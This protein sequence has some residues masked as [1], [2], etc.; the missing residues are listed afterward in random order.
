MLG[1]FLGISLAKSAVTHIADQF[2]DNVK[3]PK[4]GSILHTG[5]LGDLMEHTG[6]Y[7]GNGKIIELNNKG[8]IIE[9]TPSE[10]IDGGTGI[11]I[12][13][14]AKNGVAVGSSLIAERAI[15]F[16]SEVSVK[17]YNLLFDNCHMFTSACILDDLDNA[18]SFLWMVKDLAQK[19]IGAEEWLVWK[20]AEKF[21]DLSEQESESSVS[22]S[23]LDLHNLKV[24]LTECKK[25]DREIWS[26]IKDWV[27]RHRKHYE[28]PPHSWYFSS[29]SREASW[30]RVTGELEQEDLVSNK[31]QVDILAEM[32]KLETQIEASEQYLLKNAK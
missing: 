6:V 18:N 27:V 22:Y 4:V 7:I 31:K 12:Y 23:Q 25:L 32:K 16:E 28:N 9:V 1:K 14:S 19:S 15:K 24:Q 26:E 17:D 8:H 2:K 21:D 29:T 30:N 3:E 13:V 11:N 20:N 5:L 10:F